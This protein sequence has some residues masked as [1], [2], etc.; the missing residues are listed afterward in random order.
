MITSAKSMVKKVEPVFVV[1]S[2]LII[3]EIVAALKIFSPLILP[4]PTKIIAS[5]YKMIFTPV[6]GATLIGH[7]WASIEKFFI[8][9]FFGAALGS[10]L[11]ICMGWNKKVNSIF[12]PFFEVIRFIPPVAWISFAILWFG[13]GLAA[14]S[15]IIGIGV[16]IPALENSRQTIKLI[17]PLYIQVSHVFGVSNRTIFWKVLL[18]AG[19]PLLIAGIRIGMGIGWMCLV[20]AEM[21]SR[22]TL[23]GGKGLGYLIETSR[24][25]L[26]SEYIVGGMF[27]I[28]L[29][30][31]FMDVS[32]RYLE[33]ALCPWRR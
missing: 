14:Q 20:A 13:M 16:F 28:G 24:M 19:L 2:F 12:S 7:I 4:E 15:Y 11:G 17:D 5:L 25:T 22:P 6:G 32:I 21:I 18:P 29:I 3:W 9:F 10:F 8:G 27:L 30:G 1:L 31:Y 26:R 23:L 33:K